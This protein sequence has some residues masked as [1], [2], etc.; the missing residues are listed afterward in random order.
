MDAFFNLNSDENLPKLK[1]FE[2]VIVLKNIMHA[3]YNYS[4]LNSKFV[5]EINKYKIY[6][7]ENI[8]L[9]QSCA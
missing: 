8:S 4:E 6:T 1:M 9:H 2:I 5:K 7:Y 3:Q